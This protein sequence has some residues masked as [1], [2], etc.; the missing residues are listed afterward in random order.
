MGE[1]GKLTGRL[2]RRYETV[3]AAVWIVFAVGICGS[4]G[5]GQEGSFN[6]LCVHGG[7]SLSGNWW[8]FGICDNPNR[9][10]DEGG[11]RRLPAIAFRAREEMRF[12]KTHRCS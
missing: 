7:R 12:P 3:V 8:T 1:L 9:I 4:A 6:A 5:R 10:Q 2:P 11:G